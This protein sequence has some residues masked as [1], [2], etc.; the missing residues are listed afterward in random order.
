MVARTSVRLQAASPTPPPGVEDLLADLADGE[1]GF[2][3]TPVHGG[4]ATLA[5]FLQQCRDQAEAKSL[6]EGWVPQTIF[7]MLDD[8]GQ[9][10]GMVRMRHY[11]NDA[12]LSHGGHI[13][14]Y[15]RKDRR[16][17][18]Y[19]T[20]ALLASLRRLHALGESRALLTVD[21]A[22][23]AS[24]RVIESVG[25]HRDPADDADGEERRYWVELSAP[26]PHA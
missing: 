4:E 3:G 8:D 20:Q 19:A 1:N 6:P 10:V 16:G 26:V 7:W 13:G 14:F 24:I 2:M 18:G 23:L 15:V 17:R 5:E 25:G 11:L 12:L 9:A 22:N 21:A